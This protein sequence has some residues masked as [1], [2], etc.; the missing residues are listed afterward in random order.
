[1]L[2]EHGIIIGGGCDHQR[3]RP[4]RGERRSQQQSCRQRDAENLPRA[5]FRELPIGSENPASGRNV[6]AMPV[7]SFAN[8]REECLAFLSPGS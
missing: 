1:M 8:G 5:K 3:D 4:R 2:P 6:S 7:K